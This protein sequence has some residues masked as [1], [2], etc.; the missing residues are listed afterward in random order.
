MFKLKEKYEVDRNFLKCAF[1]K[2]SLSESNTINTKN[3]QINNNKDREDSA[4]SLL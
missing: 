3:T 4:L 2:Y 1:I